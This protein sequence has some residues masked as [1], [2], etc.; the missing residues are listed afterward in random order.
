M[1]VRMWDNGFSHVAGGSVKW[2]KYFGELFISFSNKLNI[3]LPYDLAIPF[4][5]I[6][7][8]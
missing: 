3:N 6:Q 2:C 7:V 5:G 8:K 4:P 1:L